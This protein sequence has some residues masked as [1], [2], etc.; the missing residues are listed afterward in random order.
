MKINLIE[1]LRIL[2]FGTREVDNLLIPS[3]YHYRLKPKFGQLFCLSFLNLRDS[4]SGRTSKTKSTTTI[5]TSMNSK[6]FYVVW[7][8]ICTSQYVW[9]EV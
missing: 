1:L 4:R 6:M 8:N 7:D 3:V 2:Y 9:A 5:C